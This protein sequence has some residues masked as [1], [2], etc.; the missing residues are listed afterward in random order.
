MIKTLK[1]GAMFMIAALVYG[2][3]P[4]GA[5]TVD[6]TELVYTNYK[7]DFNFVENRTYWLRDEVVYIDTTATPNPTINAI[8][9]D[10][11]QKQFAMKN[12]TQITDIEDSSSVNIVV[13][14][15][16]LK[17]TQ[18]GVNWY[19]GYGGWYGGWWGGYPSWGYPG[20]GVPVAYSYS[21]GSIFIDAFNARG[22]DN[23]D[24][25]PFVWTAAMN[26][27]LASS[28]FGQE[29]RIRRVIAQAFAQSPYL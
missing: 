25:N 10:E 14:S 7:A 18:T 8:I 27:V 15:S 2:C 20:W 21:T 6:D 13:M 9:L 24:T 19:P 1:F 17:E 23:P 3:Y 26:S 28:N 12:Y 4:K 11:I 29:T 22:F 16:V 5:E